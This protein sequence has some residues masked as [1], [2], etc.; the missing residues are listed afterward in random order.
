MVNKADKST[1]EKH[2]AADIVPIDEARRELS[3]ILADPGFQA[4]PRRR[5]MLRYIVEE[6]L[7]GRASYLKGVTI[8]QSVFGKDETFDQT[9]DPV[10]RIEARRLRRDLDS[11]YAGPGRANKLRTSI[12]KGHYVAKFAWVDGEEDPNSPLPLMGGILT[13]KMRRNL[14]LAGLVIA[15]VAILGIWRFHGGISGNDVSS[16]ASSAIPLAAAPK[17]GPSILVRRF[18]VTG[19]A[20]QLALADGIAQQLVS[21]LLRFPDIR[22]YEPTDETLDDEALARKYDISYLVDGNLTIDGAQFRFIGKLIGTQENNIIWSKTYKRALKTGNILDV[23]EEIAGDIASA[24]GQPYGV[25]KTDLGHKIDPQLG[26]YECVL[27]AYRYRL[28]PPGNDTFRPV[29]ECLEETVLKDPD[30]AEARAMLA[31]QYLDQVRFGR[32]DKTEHETM[33]AKA[34]ASASRGMAIDPSNVM[35]IKALS[36]INHYLGNYDEGNRLARQALEKNPYDPDTLYQLG[37]RLAVR[38]NF[39]EGVPLLE[40]AIARTVNPKGSYFHLLTLDRLMNG[41]GG[42]MLQLAEHGAI[43]ESALSQ[44]L[45]AIAHGQLGNM[46]AARQ[47]LLRM[48]EIS[49]RVA[50]D[51]LALFRRAQATAEI[52]EAVGAGLRRAGWPDAL[53]TPVQ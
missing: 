21:N 31:Y 15:L 16:A 29:L 51:P 42:G 18:A 39:E 12:P 48:K 20:R 17:H 38:G 10:V 44:M 34:S 14:V 49:P 24:L 5:D 1:A 30:Y 11:Y 50:E 7:S 53:S 22:I 36:A 37:W 41:D 47:A 32:V 3:K 4:S 26:S 25:I 33:L 6:T 2:E 28:H 40:R 13:N 8:A 35:A 46:D 19:D 45:V 52:I 43:E 27:S 23:E 9:V